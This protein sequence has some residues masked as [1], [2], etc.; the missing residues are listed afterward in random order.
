MEQ[1]KDLTTEQSIAIIT[2][3]IKNAK[4]NM[5]EA[6]FY[7]L[8]WGWITVIASVSQFYLDLYTDFAHPYMVWLIGIPGWII[9]MYYGYKQGKKEAV[10]TYSDG[11]IKWIW[12]GFLFCILIVIFGGKFF[13]FQITALI[14]LFAG[15]ATFINGLIIRFKPLIIGGA[16]L[17]VF[18]P[19][20]LYVGV[21]YAPLVMA[22]A[23]TVGY[24]IPGYLLKKSK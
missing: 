11:L 22:F 2:S 19:I 13:N 24:L 17:W 18:V 7:F 4:G 12:I 5:Q 6:S 10:T 20:A 23:I 9:T 21:H 14:L 8:F 3:M 1:N 15:F 16:S